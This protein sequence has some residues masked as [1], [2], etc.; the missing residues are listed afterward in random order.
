MNPVQLA[1]EALYLI[2]AVLVIL[3]VVLGLMVIGYIGLTAIR[4]ANESKFGKPDR[5]IMNEVRN[6]VTRQRREAAVDAFA[7]DLK[8]GEVI[9]D[10]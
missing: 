8:P 2:I 4:K 9:A 10:E 7:E 3:C 5:W 1:P 6:R